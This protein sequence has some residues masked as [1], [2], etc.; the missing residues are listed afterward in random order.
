MVGD[1]IHNPRGEIGLA[2]G[3]WFWWWMISAMII[4]DSILI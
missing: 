1:G 3:V 2:F 4:N